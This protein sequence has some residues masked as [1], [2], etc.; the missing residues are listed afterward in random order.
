[1]TPPKLNL[2]EGMRNPA[3]RMVQRYLTRDLRNRGLPSVNRHNAAYGSLTSQDVDAWKNAHKLPPPIDGRRWGDQAWRV[4]WPKMTRAERVVVAAY[5]ASKRKPKKTPGELVADAAMDLYQRGRGVLVYVQRRPFPLTWDLQE[6]KYRLDCSSTA[7]LCFWRA[8]QPNPNG[9]TYDGSGWTGS[10][11]PHGM[12]VQ[13]SQC[14]P[15]DLAFYGWSAQSGA[16]KHVAIVVEGGPNPTVV[17][18]G[19]TPISHLPLLY[20]SD[21]IGCRRYL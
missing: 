19:H 12:P 4:A 14:R 6:L 1:M 13:A 18:F 8:G 9:G 21:F 5:I 2:V 15:G 17:S 11:Y 16:P 20:R 7:T 10:L 3:V